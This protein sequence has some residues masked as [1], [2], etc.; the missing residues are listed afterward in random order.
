MKIISELAA[1][2]IAID[3]PEKADDFMAERV[4]ELLEVEGEKRN[5][6]QLDALERSNLCNWF[7]LH[8]HHHHVRMLKLFRPAWPPV[9]DEGAAG[10]LPAEATSKDTGGTPVSPSQ[11]ST[12]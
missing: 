4:A 2:I 11:P 9:P 3:S 8:N 6:E 12:K 10:I 1:Q 5:A 7:A